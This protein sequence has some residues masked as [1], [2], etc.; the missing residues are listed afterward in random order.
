[1]LDKLPAV[2]T[3]T[4]LLLG[5]APTVKVVAPDK[6]IEINLN[7][8]IKHEILIKVESDVED[9]IEQQGDLF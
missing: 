8:Q 2:V 7:V 6:P 3:A 9:L 4:M 1:M 5:C